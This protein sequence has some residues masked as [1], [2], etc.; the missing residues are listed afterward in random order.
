MLLTCIA[1]LVVPPDAI[2]SGYT[3][4]VKNSELTRVQ[5]NDSAGVGFG[6]PLR[7]EC[8]AVGQVR[9]LGPNTPGP[10]P[11]VSMLLLLPLRTHP[12]V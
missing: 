8:D 6:E 2:E 9:E 12:H 10:R 11:T 5:Q 4:Q 1:I 3:T 7:V